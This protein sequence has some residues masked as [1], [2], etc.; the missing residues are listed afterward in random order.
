MCIETKFN[1]LGSLIIKGDTL[2]DN[3]IRVSGEL[4]KYKFSFI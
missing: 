2:Y 4:E 3:G 1:C